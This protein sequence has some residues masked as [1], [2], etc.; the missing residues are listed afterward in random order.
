[1]NDGTKPKKVLIFSMG[2]HPFIGGA[3]IAVKEITDRIPDIEFHMVTLRFDSAL[4][5]LERIGNVVIHRIGFSRSGITTDKLRSFPVHLNKHIYQVSAPLY[6]AR[7]HK[8]HRFDATW[9][10]MAHVCGVPAAVF[11]L[12]HPSIP[13]LLTLQEGDPP[14][15]IERML[16][17]AWPLFVRA[18]TKADDVQAISSFLMSWAKRMGF[19]GEGHMIPNGVDT[20]LFAHAYADE[21]IEA[22]RREFGKK[23]GD[24]YLI[25]SSRLVHKNAVDDVIRALPLLPD[26]VSFLVYGIGRDEAKL[27][28]L[29]REQ[30]VEGRV[31]FM[32]QIGHDRLP[33]ALAASDIFIRPS[34]SEGMGNSFIEAM[35]AGLPVIATQEGGLSDFIFDAKRNPDKEV[36]AWAVD[37]DSPGQIADAVKDILAHPSETAATVARAKAL[38]LGSYDWDIVAPRMRAVFDRL[39]RGGTIQG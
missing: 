37:K 22:M 39:F 7:L 14:E 24:T 35:A 12:M 1:M 8:E 29:A 26:T 4:P 27:R 11:K 25:T 9:A 30:G 13:Y 16:W 36:T 23:E 19:R 3:E 2:Y 5:R 15:E 38:A 34:R 31:R 17:P 32:G 18:F 21:E 28:E 33:L 6:A 20:G 10:I